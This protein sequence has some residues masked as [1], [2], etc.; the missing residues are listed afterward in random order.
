M[1]ADGLTRR[2]VDANGVLLNKLGIHDEAQLARREY[3]EAAI[4]GARILHRPLPI[5]EFSDLQ[6]IHRALFGWL[7][8]WAGEVRDYDLT[9][10]TTTFLPVEFISRGI[11]TV[12][13]QITAI[14]QTS[15]PTIGQYARL[16]DS[17][18]FLHPFRE[19]NG[20][21]TKLL[22]QKLAKNK[23][24]IIDYDPNDDALVD[25]L[26]S[27]DIPRISALMWFE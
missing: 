5:N 14:N 15:V 8:D 6:A 24:Q 10:G 17:A 13:Q 22:I 21:A 9:K 7:Y 20:R 11:T 3:E 18:N 2:F 27:S 12:N 26:V 1:E 23:R 25:A 4:I 16:L 19:G